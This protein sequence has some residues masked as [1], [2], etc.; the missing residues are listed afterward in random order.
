MPTKPQPKKPT[1]S[2]PSPRRRKAAK[3]AKPFQRGCLLSG[4]LCYLG[5]A[6]LLIFVAGV[7][8]IAAVAKVVA[9]YAGDIGKMVAPLTVYFTF[10]QFAAVCVAIGIVE[11]LQVRAVW[12]GYRWGAYGLALIALSQLAF[13]LWGVSSLPAAAMAVLGTA[14]N[15]VPL[16]VLFLLLRPRWKAMR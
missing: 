14:Y 8:S 9:Q 4:C 11:L 16:I 13:A 10:S 5:C 3:K 2:K 1:S 7:L 15:N 12:Q 6:S